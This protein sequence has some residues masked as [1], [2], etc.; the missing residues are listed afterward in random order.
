MQWSQYDGS[1]VAVTQEKTGA[2]LWIPAHRTLKKELDSWRVEAKGEHV[3]VNSLGRPWPTNSFAVTFSDALRAHPQLQGLV[4]HGL[5]K[6]AAVRLAEAGC[7]THE[8]AAITGH[9]TL[10]M[11]E[12]YTRGA[13]QKRRAA[14]AM[15]KLELISNDG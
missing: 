10:A 13:D 1:A 6:S 5:R 9:E 7:S 3:L 2:S 12:L 8:I 11:V 4:F 14:A 15:R